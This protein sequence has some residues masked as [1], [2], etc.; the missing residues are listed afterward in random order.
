MTRTLPANLVEILPTLCWD[1]LGTAYEI[2]NE[3]AV[4][5][6]R[7][8]IA[9]NRAM[10]LRDRVADVARDRGLVIRRASDGT[11]MCGRPADFTPIIGGTR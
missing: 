3:R 8:S 11:Y 7:T 4:D 5:R 10:Y 2:L 6:S 1:Q 9:R